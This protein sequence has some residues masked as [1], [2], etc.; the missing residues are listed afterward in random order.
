[1]VITANDPEMQLISFARAWFKLLAQGKWDVALAML[2]EPNSYSIRWTKERILALLQ[3]PFGPT[4]HFATEFGTPAFS[5]PDLAN[6]TAGHSFGKF[7]AG[8][9]WLNHNVPLN[10]VFSDLTAQFEFHPRSNGYVAVLHDLHV[11]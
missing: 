1:M 4:T 9:F 11:L 2:D 8:G 10:G 5:D 3:D 7:D 6:G